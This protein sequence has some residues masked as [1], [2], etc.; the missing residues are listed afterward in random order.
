MAGYRKQKLEAQIQRIVGTVLLTEIKD[1]RVGF[2]TVTGVNLSKDYS[3]ADIMV[4][5][6]GDEKE[7]KKSL[8]GLESARKYIQY[9]VGKNIQLRVLPQ[10]RFHVDTSIKDGV[11]MVA[12]LEKIERDQVTSHEND[13]PEDDTRNP[14][15]TASD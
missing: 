14:G 13:D 11:E 1:P 8:M 6:I 10:I 5:V 2:V 3:Y 4:S 9:R 7:V 12:R 15:D